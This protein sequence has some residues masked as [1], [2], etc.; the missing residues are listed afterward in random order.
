MIRLLIFSSIV[1]FPTVILACKC[2]S[3]T[4]PTTVV[5]YNEFEIIVS[6]QA[7][8]VIIDENEARN[9]Q[10][11]IAFKIDEIFKGEGLEKT[12]KI[13]TRQ[14]GCGL[15]V[16]E[17]EE[18]IIW[19]YNN[20]DGSISTNACTRSKRKDK[21]DEIELKTLQYLKTNPSTTE[22]S[23][24]KGQ[25]VATGKM[26][27]NQPIGHWRY[28]YYDGAMESQGGY[29]NGKKDGKWF[30]YLNPSSIIES[31]YE[32]KVIPKDSVPDQALFINSV[33]EIGHFKEGLRHGEFV[34]YAYFSVDKP[35][36]IRNYKH[37]RKEGLE[38]SYHSNGLIS[39]VYNYKDGKLDGPVRTYHPNGQLKMIG[40]YSDYK[41]I[42]E[43]KLFNE[44]GELVKTTVDK[45]PD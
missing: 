39:Y 10:V 42:G 21:I 24:E 40:Q 4:G 20:S 7:T 26:E 13:Y 38:I 16:K 3:V 30:S 45:R 36:R 12:L 1:V 23:N 14:Y 35:H 9:K 44:D 22:W 15:P 19:A 41:P 17:N 31:L 18:W 43:F 25:K 6:G 37:G 2:R 5:D 27:N 29:V 32:D 28:Y 8:K 34:D 11:Q 33:S